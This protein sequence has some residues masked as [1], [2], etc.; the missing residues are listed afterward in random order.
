MS[1]KFISTALIGLCALAVAWGIPCAV[2]AEEPADEEGM[3]MEAVDRRHRYLS[4]KLLQAAES[5][6]AFVMNRFRSTDEQESEIIRQF[7]GDRQS[8]YDVEGSYLRISQVAAFA[9]RDDEDFKTRFSVRL[10]LADISDRLQFFADSEEADHNV[11]G[12]VYSARY[13]R[14]LER[15]RREGGEAGLAY[16]FTDRLQ[17][18]LS[19]SGG[20]RFR[21]EPSPRTRLRT[22][23]RWPFEVWRAQL[24]QSLFWDLENG[25]GEKSQAEFRRPIREDYVFRLTSAAVWSELSEGVDWSQ[26]AAFFASL[27]RRRSASLLMGVRGHTHPSTVTD[28]YVIR[29]RYRQRIYRDWLYVGVEPGADFFKDDGYRFAPLINLKME[30]YVGSY[31]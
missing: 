7:Y 14:E 18:D 15:E 16:F 8:A 13:R 2:T 9:S 1:R 28:Q 26:F 24:T 6:N 22:R 21:P 12:D 5:I 23:V 20:M 3:V 17:R 30:I 31:G 29:V 27:S 10:R 11:M 25:F 19:L 4:R